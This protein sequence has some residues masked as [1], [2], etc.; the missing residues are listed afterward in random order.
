MAV[1]CFTFDNLGE[2]ADIADGSRPSEVDPHGHPSLTVGLPRVLDLL[3]SHEVAATFFVEGWNGVHHPDAV[4]AIARAGHEVGMHGWLHEP[5][6][7]LSP[8]EERRLAEEA[9]SALGQAVGDAPVGF[10]APGGA[11]TAATPT[12]LHDLGYHYD[13]SLDPDGGHRPRR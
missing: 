8:A 3:A 13:A 11:T 7:E 9:T 4:R 12:I 6:A 2:A 10:R 5:W 1:A